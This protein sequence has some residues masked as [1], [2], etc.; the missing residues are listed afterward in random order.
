MTEHDLHLIEI[1]EK[2]GAAKERERI[3]QSILMWLG[4]YRDDLSPK[5]IAN[6]Q[7]IARAALGE[8]K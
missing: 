6:L 5:A 4:T 3:G 8:A 2:A 1:G 7:S